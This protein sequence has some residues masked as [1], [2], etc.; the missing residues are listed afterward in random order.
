M[1][2]G[3]LFEARQ[4]AGF[5]Q[6]Q[7]TRYWDTI[8]KEKRIIR[9]ATNGHTNASMGPFYVDFMSCRKDRCG[10]GGY[11]FLKKTKAA[12]ATQ[13]LSGATYTVPTLA[14]PRSGSGGR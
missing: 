3:V 8:Q 2:E 10:H 11:S 4:T 1:L 6:R 12:G 9:L 13:R 5:S 7:M 14:L